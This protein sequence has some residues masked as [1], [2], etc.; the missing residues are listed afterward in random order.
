[1]NVYGILF[2]VRSVEKNRRRRR[3]SQED[4]INHF[5]DVTAVQFSGNVTQVPVA[6]RVTPSPP[7]LNSDSDSCDQSVS[8]SVDIY[9]IVATVFSDGHFRISPT[10]P[11][12]CHW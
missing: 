3:R 8:T 9:D 4:V 6:E 12:Y 11:D 2:V 5:F 10:R 1:M 7:H